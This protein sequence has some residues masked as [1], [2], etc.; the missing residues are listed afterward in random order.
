MNEHSLEGN[1][2]LIKPKKLFLAQTVSR[3]IVFCLFIMGFLYFPPFVSQ[4]RQVPDSESY[5]E[6]RF[7]AESVKHSLQILGRF[8]IG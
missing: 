1:T 4:E 3:K 7:S 8:L 2:C 6:S 5:P